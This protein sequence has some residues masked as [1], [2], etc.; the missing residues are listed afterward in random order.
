MRRLGEVEHEAAGE[1]PHDERVLGPEL[2]G[3]ERGVKAKLPWKDV[4][5]FLSFASRSKSAIF[6]NVFIM[7]QPLF[8][9]N[10]DKLPI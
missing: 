3:K 8:E 7:F 9:P 6:V 5:G 10:A 4:L 2:A 1:L